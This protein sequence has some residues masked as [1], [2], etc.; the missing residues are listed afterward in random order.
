M[1]STIERLY[2]ERAGQKFAI[3]LIDIKED[4]ERVAAWV[5][6]RGITV[7]VLV[8]QD[9]AVTSVYRVTAT[10]TVFLIGR[11]GR[12]VARA[13]G[14]RPWNNAPSRELLD[15]LLKTPAK[16]SR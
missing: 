16:P 10:P 1:P 5:K 14:T 11:D 2:R 13:S 12:L 6:A 3:L 9:G 4:P 8:D 15:V 7:P